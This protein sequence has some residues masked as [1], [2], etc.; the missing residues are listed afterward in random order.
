MNR[1]ARRDNDLPV[2]D[3]DM[4]SFMRRSHQVNDT[5]VLRQVE[6]E[7]NLGPAH[8]RV[9]RHGIPHAPGTQLREAH[10]QLAA[11]CTVKKDEFVDAPMIGRF[12]RAKRYR[13][14]RT[15]CDL[16]RWITGMRWVTQ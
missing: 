11:L 7:I 8:M 1:P 12:R 6:V 10:D 2:C 14:R 9:R 16:G 4:P 5:V 3:R 15:G 13:L